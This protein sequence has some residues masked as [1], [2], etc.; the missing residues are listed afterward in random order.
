MSEVLSGQ[1]GRLFIELRDRKSLAYTVSAFSREA[2]DPGLIAGYIAT[3][4]E[5]KDE[6]I[7][8]LLEEFRKLRVEPV[9]E[10][11]L[12]RAK[13]SIIGNYEIGLQS[14]SS[15]AADMANNELFRALATRSPRSTPKRYRPSPLRT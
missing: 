9:R 6:A 2:V 11:E 4:P 5:K 3:A 1:G 7:K 8:G 13:S 12:A 10:E 14:V 15:Q